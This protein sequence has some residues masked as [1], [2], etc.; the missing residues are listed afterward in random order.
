MNPEFLIARCE[1]NYAEEELSNNVSKK[2]GFG[3]GSYDYQWYEIVTYSLEKIEGR[4]MDWFSKKTFKLVK[5]EGDPIFENNYLTDKH[6]EIKM[7]AMKTKRLRGI[8]NKL[9]GGR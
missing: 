2:Y 5:Y 3:R 1:F 4:E 8:M 7:L 6:M 9:E